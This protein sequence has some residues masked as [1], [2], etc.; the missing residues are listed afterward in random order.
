[1]LIDQ[2]IA[3]GTIAEIATGTREFSITFQMP[4]LHLY[5]I[6]ATIALCLGVFY[7]FFKTIWED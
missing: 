3:T 2:I 6:I 5:F 7:L 1:M 4:A